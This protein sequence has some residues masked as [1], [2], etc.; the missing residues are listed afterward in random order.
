MNTRN[1]LRT[2]LSALS[3]PKHLIPI[4]ILVLPV[5][6]L[7]WIYGGEPA[8]TAIAAGMGVTFPILAPLLWRILLSDAAASHRTMRLLLYGL[9]GVANVYLWGLL[10]PTPFH[11]NLTL[12]T[13]PPSLV[14]ALVIFWVGDW[15]L[16]RDIELELNLDEQ[17][18][19]NKRIAREATHAQIMAAKN[20]L[21]PHFIFNTFPDSIQF[22]LSNP[23]PYN[24]LRDGGEGIP[25]LVQR[26]EVVYNGDAAFS[27]RQVG[28]AGTTD[29]PRW[30][31]RQ[32][33]EC[34]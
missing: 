6:G 14:A 29:T 20:Y 30:P 15:S 13:D 23:G 31:F 1:L 19:K 21:D 11:M 27:I 24:G 26:L 5:I 7:E 3:R 16:G 34:A 22:R 8:E 2:T 18:A 28:I 12:I 9:L 17:I 25:M 32:P 33:E 4:C 10:L